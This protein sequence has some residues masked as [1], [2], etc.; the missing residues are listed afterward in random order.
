MRLE[1]GHHERL[2]ALAGGDQPVGR[3]RGRVVVVGQEDGQAGDVAVG[4]VGIPGPDG[5]LLRRPLAVEHGLLGIEVDADD[6]GQLG[7]RR[8]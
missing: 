2:A 1:P 5:Q 3:D 4:A 7:W 8:R 6:R